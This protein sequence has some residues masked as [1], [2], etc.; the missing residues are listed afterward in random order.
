MKERN[1]IRGEKTEYIISLYLEDKIWVDR[2]YQR[3]LVWEES[4]KKLFIQSLFESI[5]VPAVIYA[6]RED[7]NGAERYEIIDGL[8][9][10]NAIVSFMM[11]EFP[12][13]IDGETGYF[14]PS[15]SH[16]TF[17]VLQ[18]GQYPEND[19][20]LDSKLCYDFARIEIPVI[21]IPQND[22][23]IEKIF[24]RIN[25]TGRKLSPQDIRQSLSHNRFS[26]NNKR[27]LYLF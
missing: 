7:E 8:Q 16:P 26:D 10:T 12:V 23:Y 9:R 17:G 24:N 1:D 27:G 5:P 25:S 13:D 20:L 14:D 19:K 11:G 6:Y 22:M 18:K 21:I 3:K 15:Q 4:D 2:K